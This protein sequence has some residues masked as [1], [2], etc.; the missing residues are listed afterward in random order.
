[1]AEDESMFLPYKKSKIENRN[2]NPDKTKTVTF[3]VTIV[4]S[5][6]TVSL[7]VNG[8]KKTRKFNI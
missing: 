4:T 8:L 3:I 2:I 5:V 1:M 7:I 6:N